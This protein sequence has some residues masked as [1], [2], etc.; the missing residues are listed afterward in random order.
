VPYT[1]VIVYF[2]FKAHSYFAATGVFI[3]LPIL[4]KGF[5]FDSSNFWIKKQE[6]VFKVAWGITIPKRFDHHG[7][8]S[9]FDECD[10]IV[11]AHLL[12]T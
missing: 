7:D 10:T 8:L 6:F 3:R 9:K 1:I 5:N 4:E 11:G 2:L 12:P